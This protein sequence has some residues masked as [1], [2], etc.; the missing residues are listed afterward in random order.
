MKR[1]SSAGAKARAKVA[2]EGEKQ[3]ESWAPMHAAVR[4]WS[5]A[6]SVYTML[7]YDAQIGDSPQ[8]M[9]VQEAQQQAGIQEKQHLSEGEEGVEMGKEENE[10]KQQPQNVSINGQGIEEIIRALIQKTS[11]SQ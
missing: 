10:E 1:S 5:D 8:A 9:V 2:K 6:D 3:T 11:Q 7:S 4:P